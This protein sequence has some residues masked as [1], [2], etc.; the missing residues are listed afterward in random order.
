MCSACLKIHIIIAAIPSFLNHIQTASIPRS[1]VIVISV[2]DRVRHIRT[3]GARLRGVF[4][5]EV[6]HN[7]SRLDVPMFEAFRQALLIEQEISKFLGPPLRFSTG[8]P[9]IL[10]KVQGFRS[11]ISAVIE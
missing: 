7:M 6:A 10:T 4:V 8:S 2:F 9:I 11:F 5:R 1:E 3:R